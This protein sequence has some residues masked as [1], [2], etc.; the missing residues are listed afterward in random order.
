[1]LNGPTPSA[2]ELATMLRDARARTLLLAGSFQGD[3]LLGPRLDLVNPPLWE[4]GHMGWFQERWCLRYAGEGRLRPSLLPGADALYDSSCVPHDSRWELALP[5]LEK[6]L[7]YLEQGLE[8]VLEGLEQDGADPQ[9]AY[10][11]QLAVFHEDMHNEALTYTR[12]TLGYTA[13]PMPAGADGVTGPWPGDV[14]I[15]GG[16]LM[17]GAKLWDGFVFDNEKWTHPVTVGPFRMARAPV[18]H[19]EFLAFVEDGGYT[20]RELWSGEGWSWLEGARAQGPVYWSRCGAEWRIRWFAEERGLPLDV[21][22]MFVNWHEARAYCRWARR[23]L[24]TEAEWEMAAAMS[25]RADPGRRRYPWGDAAPNGARANLYGVVGALADVAAFPEGDSAWGCRQMIGNVWEW[26][27]DTFLPYP[28]F[29]VDPYRDYSAPW[30]AS[31][32]VLRG[33][34]FATAPRLI[35]NTWRNFYTPERRDVFAGF[36]TC[37]AE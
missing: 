10:F 5:S 21:P 18:T 17:M 9:Q 23:R 3:Q 36:R 2:S 20:R 8:R 7:G 22:V 19:R 26:T 33:G 12:Q 25:P 27:A 30:F 29:V 37:A 11:I 24:P 34:C 14:E 16:E 32:K 13:P 1:M 28:G 15:P 31:H 35:R 6:T 4:L